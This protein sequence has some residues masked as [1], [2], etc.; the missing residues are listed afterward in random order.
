[1]AIIIKGY[2]HIH[3]NTIEKHG[4]LNRF[5]RL[6]AGTSSEKYL[7]TANDGSA[8]LLR[9]YNADAE[10]NPG[11]VAELNGRIFSAGI[12]IPV[13]LETGMS[14][15]GAF[16]FELNEWVVGRSLDLLLDGLP[17]VAQYQKGL[18]AGRFLKII[19]SVKGS[20]IC[21]A[22][23]IPLYERIER[24]VEQ[25][26]ILK[27][28]GLPT[29]KGAAFIQQLMSTP[30]R[31]GQPKDR[32]LHGDYHTG[33]I[34]EDTAGDIWAIDWIYG[35]TGDPIDDFV[36]IFVSADLHPHFARG[37]VDGY[38][39]G[40]PPLEFWA[41]L[42]FF[43]SLQQLEIL[44]LPLGSLPNGETIWE[45]QHR[46]IFDQYSG[47]RSE[48]PRFYTIKGGENHEYR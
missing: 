22:G 20:A 19:H 1:M 29:Y 25:Y 17:V 4:G 23:P 42:K 12:K 34:I 28:K 8:Y 18:S 45:H 9:L 14:E 40:V 6:K 44:S 38:F 5:V 30:P 15:D 32:L 43:A 24:A 10:N 21:G 47:M 26:D 27:R 48:I 2:M 33:N 16:W 41:E 46:I 37:Q 35:L 7:I 39:S 11:L 31:A 13:I 3:V 36:R